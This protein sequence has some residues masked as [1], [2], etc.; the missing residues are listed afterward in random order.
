[1]WA[2]YLVPSGFRE[3][4]AIGLFADHRYLGMVAVHTDTAA[5]PTDGALDLLQLI[6]PTIARAVDP[7]RGISETAHD[8]HGLRLGV[9]TAG[10]QRGL[11]W[12]QAR[13]GHSTCSANASCQSASEQRDSGT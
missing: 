3:G 7:L 13:S 6:A 9:T 10:V 11:P 1:M 8:L 5:H 4:G 2:D 12:R